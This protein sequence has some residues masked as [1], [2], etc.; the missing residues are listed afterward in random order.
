MSDNITSQFPEELLRAF[1]MGT[2]RTP[3]D[4]SEGRYS[5]A[6]KTLSEFMRA[7]SAEGGYRPLSSHIAFSFSFKGW[8]SKKAKK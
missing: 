8:L 3:E 5:N 6:E 1:G 7:E 2:P 4:P